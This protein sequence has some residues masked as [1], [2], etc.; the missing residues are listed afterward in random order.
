MAGLAIGAGASS[1]HLGASEHVT[2]V[3]LSL[4]MLWVHRRLGRDIDEG[5]A[6]G[7]GG[8]ADIVGAMASLLM[9]STVAQ[10]V[11]G[12]EAAASGEAGLSNWFLVVS[13]AA[14]LVAVAVFLHGIAQA[15]SAG[16]L[17]LTGMDKH[18]CA[19]GGI[20]MLLVAASGVLGQSSWLAPV[21]ARGILH[22]A[23]CCLLWVLLVRV[24]SP[25]HLMELPPGSG[26]LDDISRTAGKLGRDLIGIAGVVY[27]AAALGGLYRTADMVIMYQ[28]GVAALG[29]G[30]Y[31]KARRQLKGVIARNRVLK[32]AAIG[33]GATR[34]LVSALLKLGDN[35]AAEELLE[36]LAV[37]SERRGKE[38]LRQ[39]AE[40]H[41]SAGLYDKAALLYRELV[42]KPFHPGMVYRLY[43]SLLRSGDY[44]GAE[45]AVR[46]P[47]VVP[48]A[49]VVEAEDVEG[50]GNLAMLYGMHEQATQL[51]Q[52]S[53]EQG[54]DEARSRY[55]LALIALSR[56]QYRHG[57]ELLERVTG[58]RDDFADAHH[59]LGLC[60]EGMAMG[61]RAA[62]EFRRAQGLL[63]NH[64]EALDGLARLMGDEG[65]P[66]PMRDRRRRLTPDVRVE[67]ETISGIGLVGFGGLPESAEVGEAVTFY[68]HWRLA[69]SG[70]YLEL[71]AD[72]LLAYRVVVR[73]VSLGNVV[74]REEQG[75]SVAVVDQR[76]APLKYAP[77]EWELG[78]VLRVRHRLRTTAYPSRLW[79]DGKTVPAE[80]TRT[81]RLPVNAPYTIQCWVVWRGT[82]HPAGETRVYVTG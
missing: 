20:L 14:V 75:Q 30:E 44:R 76:D 2:L 8:R 25:Q 79:V 29:G 17:S 13:V 23:L 27:L 41:W 4:G 32:V 15:R 71:P 56:G 69:R 65:L 52:R 43:T 37:S 61:D 60:Y 26:P 12:D 68:T 7:P 63:P 64:L 38:D 42:R 6:G 72:S 51:F 11:P 16:A 78:G 48:G 58:V 81:H 62:Q 54:R 10:F 50:L 49:E 24:Y 18:V 40:M 22:I 47:R 19:A 57:E 45:A 70:L 5:A 55:K 46:G 34:A 3:I 77:Q 21:T 9:V 67:R 1:L 82:W 53:V 66:V 59:Q 33:D 80:Q 35:R 31:G 73:L 39:I 36:T 28:D 74:S